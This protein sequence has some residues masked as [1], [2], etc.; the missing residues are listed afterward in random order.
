MEGIIKVESRFGK[1]TTFT[2]SFPSGSNSL[3]A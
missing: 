1:G 3:A 2:I